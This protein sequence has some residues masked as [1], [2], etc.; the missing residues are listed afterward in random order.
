LDSDND[1][2]LPFVKQILA[3]LKR[4]KRMIN[5]IGDYNDD[6]EGGNGN[7]TKINWLKIT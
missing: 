6:E 7:F 3:S 4:V 5:L 1:D 2:D